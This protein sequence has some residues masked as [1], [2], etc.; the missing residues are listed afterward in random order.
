MDLMLLFLVDSYGLQNTIPLE[1]L[2]A[3]T[4]ILRPVIYAP[5]VN[6]VSECESTCE[7]CSLIWRLQRLNQGWPMLNAKV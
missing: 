3:V 2:C 6:S 5:G 7:F 1:L 4:Q